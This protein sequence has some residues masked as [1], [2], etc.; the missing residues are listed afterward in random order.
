MTDT[1]AFQVVYIVDP[2]F[3]KQLKL[4]QKQKNKKKKKKQLKIKIISFQ[5]TDTS[6]NIRHLF[7]WS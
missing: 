4:Q 1:F 3:T 5:G 7:S 2:Q 6:L